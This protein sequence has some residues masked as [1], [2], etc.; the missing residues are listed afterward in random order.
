M[1]ISIFGATGATGQELIKQSLANGYHIS[2]IVRNKLDVSSPLLTIVKGSIFDKELVKKIIDKS[3]LVISVVAFTPKLFGQKSTD[4]YAKTASVIVEAMTELNL[5]K[6]VFCTSAGVE[7]DP[8]E[9]WFYKYILKPFYLKKGYMNMLLAEEKIIN[10]KLDWILVRPS[11][12]TN[13]PLTGQFRV[14]DRFRPKGGSCISRAD[15]AFFMLEQLNNNNYVH[16]T[17]TIAY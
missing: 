6:L 3:D 4:L 17:P 11:R 9:I 10:S 15:L 8:N 1:K 16:K 12:L 5:K 2:T 7:N 13:S 14:S